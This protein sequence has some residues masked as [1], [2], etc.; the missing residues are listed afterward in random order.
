MDTLQGC[1]VIGV[2]TRAVHD[3]PY[4]MPSLGPKKQGGLVCSFPD[5]SLYEQP[6]RMHGICC[7]ASL[8]ET[9]LVGHDID[10]VVETVFN[11]TL[12]DIHVV[13]EQANWLV[14]GAF[15]D[16]TFAFANGHCLAGGPGLGHFIFRHN[17]VE[18]E[19]EELAPWCP[20]TLQTW[21]AVGSSCLPI[22]HLPDCLQDFCC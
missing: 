21:D 20:S 8:Y 16:I 5:L 6:G 1:C 22:L 14:V 13:A 2:R 17:L 18:Q 7:S 19:G 3:G 12:K 4:Q 15:V 10:D 11:N 9:T